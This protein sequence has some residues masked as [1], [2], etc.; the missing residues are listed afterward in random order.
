MYT[1]TDETLYV[2]SLGDLTSPSV[3]YQIGSRCTSALI[4]DK[5]LYLGGFRELHIFEV[6]STLTE[7]LTLL[8][9]IVLEAYPFKIFRMGDDLL[10]G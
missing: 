3:P 5:R 1:E 2:Y 10:L 9:K 7:P 8:T 4:T 6:T